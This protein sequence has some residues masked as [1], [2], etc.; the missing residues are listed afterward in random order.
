MSDIPDVETLAE[1][2]KQNLAK[3]QHELDEISQPREK[4]DI[5]PG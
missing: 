5:P 2:T 4:V 3:M 1:Q